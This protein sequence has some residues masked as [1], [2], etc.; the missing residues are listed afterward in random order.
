MLIRALSSRGRGSDDEGVALL[1]AVALTALAAAMMITM[2]MLVVRENNST[3]RDRDRS[4]S[5]MTAEGGIDTALA[6]IPKAAVSSIP[7]GSTTT[8]GSSANPEVVTLTTTVKYFDAAGTQL[9]C[10]LTDTMYAAQASVR[11]SA[12][13]IPR[14]GGQQVTRTMETLVQLKPKYAND[15]DRAIFGNAGVTVSNNFDLYGQSGPDADVYTNGS[16]TCDQNEHFRGSIYAQGAITV[17]GTC[18]IDV[19]ANA[20]TGF[21]MTNTKAN[22]GGDVLVANGS[23]NVSS[24]TVGGKVKAVSVTPASYCTSN[25]S[26]CVTGAGSAPVPPVIAFPQVGQTTT[27]WVSNGY[28]VVPVSACDH[29]VNSADGYLANKGQSLTGKTL[30]VV[31]ATLPSG[32]TAQSMALS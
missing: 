8:T 32:C 29:S 24:G 10:P 30:L 27:D 18:T 14:G 9:P 15:L 12:V 16:F 23:A 11:S 19:N 13:S 3:G 25:P 5:V 6:Q 17:S 7:C 20:K 26:K 1:V 21:S 22:V 4:V 31:P 2:M 28:T